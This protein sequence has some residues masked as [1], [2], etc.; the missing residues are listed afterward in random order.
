MPEQRRNGQEVFFC[1]RVVIGDGSKTREEVRTYI[2]WRN[3][4]HHRYFRFTRILA[5]LSVDEGV[6]SID[7]TARK[8]WKI[9][10]GVFSVAIEH[11]N[12]IAENVSQK[13]KKKKAC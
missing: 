7:S 12:R 3:Q 2:A 4:A 8:R 6:H 11:S 1:F 5:F 13:K 9:L 10:S